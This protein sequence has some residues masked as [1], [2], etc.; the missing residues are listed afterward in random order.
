MWEYDSAAER[1][2]LRGR[3]SGRTFRLGDGL[4]VAVAK[5]DTVLR[6]VDFELAAEEGR[7][8]RR[9]ARRD[10]AR[11]RSADP[12]NPWRTLTGRCRNP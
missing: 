12:G 5:V 8:S 10:P 3:D 4:R 9:R 11:G 6:R 7:G 2:E 1:L